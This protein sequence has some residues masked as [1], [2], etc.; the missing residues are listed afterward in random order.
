LLLGSLLLAW[1]EVR[2]LTF[3]ISKVSPFEISKDAATQATQL[4]SGPF[5]G[6]VFGHNFFRTHN[7]CVWHRLRP[8]PVMHELCALLVTIFMASA[9]CWTTVLPWMIDE[10]V[11]PTPRRWHSTDRGQGTRRI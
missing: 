1:P 5:R 2:S 10:A 3:L 8:L 4:L 9:A 6:S 11:I 7:E